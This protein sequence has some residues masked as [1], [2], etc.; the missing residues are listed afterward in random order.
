MYFHVKTHNVAVRNVFISV[1]RRQ[2]ASAEE[3][4]HSLQL[5][6]FQSE[7][8]RFGICNLPGRGGKLRISVTAGW[9]FA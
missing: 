8:E 6:N 2:T 9:R 4:I 1:S 3:V 5:E 7:L